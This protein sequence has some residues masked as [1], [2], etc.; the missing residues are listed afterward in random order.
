MLP[1]QFVN[2]RVEVG[3]TEDFG[4]N[5]VAFQVL[6]RDLQSFVMIVILVCVPDVLFSDLRCG[7]LARI[8][9]PKGLEVD[10]LGDTGCRRKC[11]LRCSQR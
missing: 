2:I 9:V 6:D 1:H 8:T 10:R 11:L 7:L 5:L 4:I 3:V